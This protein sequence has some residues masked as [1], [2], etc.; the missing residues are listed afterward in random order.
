[1]ASNKGGRQALRRPSLLSQL[2]RLRAY[3][4]EW[5]EDRDAWKDRPRHDDASHADSFLTF[6]CSSYTPPSAGAAMSARSIRAIP[7]GPFQIPL[8]SQC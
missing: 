3:R 4:K 1:M 6:A 7:H 2:K 5:D 8:A